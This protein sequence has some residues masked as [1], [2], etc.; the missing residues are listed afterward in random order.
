MASLEDKKRPD[1]QSACV[2]D[3]KD[4]DYVAALEDTKRRVAEIACGADLQEAP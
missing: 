3:F 4:K 2:A 1:A